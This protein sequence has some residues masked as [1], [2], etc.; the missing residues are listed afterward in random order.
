MAVDPSGKSIF[1][2]DCNGR[3]INDRFNA[4]MGFMRRL[5]SRVALRSGCDDDD[6]AG[7]LLQLGLEDLLEMD[8]AIKSNIATANT[9]LAATRDLSL[10][11]LRNLKAT[12]KRNATGN[13]PNCVSPLPNDIMA[14]N[15]AMEARLEPRAIE[16]KEK[17]AYKDRKLALEEENAKL[18]SRK[19][20]LEEKRYEL[21]LKRNSGNNKE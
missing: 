6:D 9:S 17:C 4:L 16:K 1:P 2:S 21:A 7:K 15:K 5:E 13:V 10:G 14:F 12:R 8:N 11:D 19:L 18:N 3:Q 20:A